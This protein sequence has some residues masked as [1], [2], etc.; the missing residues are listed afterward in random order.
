M[1]YSKLFLLIGI[2]FGGGF[3]IQ[4][5][6]AQEPISEM[7][8]FIP[9]EDWRSMQYRLG[10]ESLILLDPL[11]MTAVNATLTNPYVGQIILNNNTLNHP[12]VR[13]ELASRAAL[14]ASSPTASSSSTDPTNSITGLAAALVTDNQT[15]SVTSQSISDTLNPGDTI[16][17]TLSGNDRD[18]DFLTFFID[19]QPQYGSLS[20]FTYI[21]DYSATVVY[22]AGV[23]FV[24]T[25][26]FKF[27]ANDCTL[28][29]SIGTIAFSQPVGEEIFYD[30]FEEG[31]RSS[32]VLIQ[33]TTENLG[34]EEWER[35]Q[36]RGSNFPPWSTYF[37]AFSEDCNGT[38][39][40]KM[41]TDI[42]LT[43]Y[44][45]AELTLD[46]KVDNTMDS[47][48][49][50][51]LYAL[52][53]NTQTEL[54]ELSYDNGY[55]NESWEHRVIDLSNYLTSTNFNLQFN[56]ISSE[57]GEYVEVDRIQIFGEKI[58]DDIDP[59]V[60]I[61]GANPQIIE[62]GEGYVEL[63]AQVDDHSPLIIDK[64]EFVDELGTYTIHYS[65][66][67]NSGNT[68]RADREVIVEDTTD[69]TFELEDMYGT[70][71]LSTATYSEFENNLS[72]LET[73]YEGII[74][75][76]V[77]E[78]SDY[79]TIKYLDSS[80]QEIT[81]FDQTVLSVGTY[82]INYTVSDNVTPPNSDTI[83]EK[84]IVTNAAP[85]IQSIERFDPA[86]QDTTQDKVKFKVTF[87]EDVTDVN[88]WDFETTMEGSWPSTQVDRI[89]KIS[90]SVYNV[91]ASLSSPGGTISVKL[92]SNFDNG[93][94]DADSASIVELSPVNDPETYI[95]TLP[96]TAPGAP[97]R[98]IGLRGGDGQVR[99]NWANPL[100]DGGSPVTEF[101]IYY[102]NSALRVDGFEPDWE[103]IATVA[104]EGPNRVTITGLEN[105]RTYPFFVTS[106]NAVGESGHSWPDRI[107]LRNR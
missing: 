70:I 62:L 25:D 38:C 74:S 36:F 57:N 82:Y 84:I 88:W 79:S 43:Q 4:F 105:G 39:I 91:T 54:L 28:R 24:D 2:V 69:P 61:D 85:R 94:T 9:H 27:Y 15:P 104:S 98:Y 96:I 87:T 12:F 45:S 32:D 90:D 6:V 8:Y 20:D 106:V 40:M 33:W 42:D 64:S 78:S 5:S 63:G 51:W 56:A 95:V 44:T 23:N 67:D 65:A 49:G 81:S 72:D 7:S 10:D 89:D 29:S 1:I 100:W 41:N 83:T 58:V 59:I 103:I 35:G 14:T 30:D 92:K 102:Q 107:H 19:T 3:L 13:N 46:V 55:A 18:A 66:T 80:L 101:N 71:H 21:D 48:E 60:T 52:D 11:N 86:T 53:G 17:V 75:N 93:I 77:D 31:N 68:G 37:L 50:F 76:I 16:T 34:D 99:V 47:G 22:T 97:D 73:F 26:S